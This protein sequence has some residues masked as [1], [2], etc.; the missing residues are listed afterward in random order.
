MLF[1]LTPDIDECST[2]NECHQNASCKNTK[3]SYICTCQD[4]LEGDGKYCTAG[5]IL[6][7]IIGTTSI[8]KKSSQKGNSSSKCLQF[9]LASARGGRRS[10]DARG[11]KSRNNACSYTVRCLSPTNTS[12]THDQSK[13]R[14]RGSFKSKFD[15]ESKSKGVK[16]YLRQ[17]G[18]IIFAKSIPACAVRSYHNSIACSSNDVK[19]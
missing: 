9:V 14:L 18:N 7:K 13:I 3:G 6:F 8:Q 11:E 2:K 19:N 17:L 10:G 16:N 15:L 1:I 4:G 12:T 5:K